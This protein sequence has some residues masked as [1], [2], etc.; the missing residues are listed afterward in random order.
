[1]PHGTQ[2]ALYML[3]CISIARPLEH[4]RRGRARARGPRG[5]LGLPGLDART[6]SVDDGRGG[7]CRRRG[8]A[9]WEYGIRLAGERCP[10][11]A[12]VRPGRG[13][14][15]GPRLTFAR[16]ADMQRAAGSARRPVP[17]LL[18]TSAPRRRMPRPRSPGRSPTHGAAG[19]AP[20][21]SSRLPA[22]GGASHAPSVVWAPRA[23]PAAA[24]TALPARGSPRS[25]AHARHT[26]TSRPS[27]LSPAHLRI[28]ARR[29]SACRSRTREDARPC[30]PRCRGRDTVWTGCPRAPSLRIGQ[31]MEYKKQSNHGHGGVDPIHMH[32]HHCNCPLRQP[33][34]PDRNRDNPT[35]P[36]TWL[37]TRNSSAPSIKAPRAR[38]S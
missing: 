27:V 23:P 36:P 30:A 38:G 13:C 35:P 34:I 3:R 18:V 21:H 29:V 2:P 17:A 24:A 1:M 31:R 22:W 37:P 4:S 15:A 8:A 11:P 7:G 25:C 6:H 12:C 14:R 26:D 32:H 9:P 10:R 28:C 16:S 33:P 5:G 20:D 19:P